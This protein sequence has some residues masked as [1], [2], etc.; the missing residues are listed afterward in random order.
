MSS[1][2]FKLFFALGI[3]IF[4]AMILWLIPVSE[5]RSGRLLLP[6]NRSVVSAGAEIY[7]AQCASCH[8]ANLEGEPDWQ[9]RDGEGY[10]P[11]PPH[12]A[13]GHTWHHTDQVLFRLTKYGLSKLSGLESYKTRMPAYEGVLTDE[14]IIAVLSFI[15]SQWPANIRQ[16]HDEMNAADSRKER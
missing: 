13:E 2:R 9:S 8:G 12:D 14:E 16:R 1:T 6:E 15:K 4:A 3:A 10:L 11:A 5:T 7:A